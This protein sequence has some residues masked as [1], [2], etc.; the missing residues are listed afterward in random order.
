MD[1]RQRLRAILRLQRETHRK[2]FDLQGASIAG[3]REALEAIS[4]SHDEMAVLFESDDRLDDAI[5]E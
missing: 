5:E 2:L 4:R 3:L 1:R